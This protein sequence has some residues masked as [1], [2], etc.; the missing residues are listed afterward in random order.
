MELNIILFFLLF[1]TGRDRINRHRSSRQYLGSYFEFE[2]ITAV[3]EEEK[4][5]F[6]PVNANDISP[7]DR[8]IKTRLS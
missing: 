3:T 4:S 1:I 2:R 6:V 7:Q 5:L 8:I